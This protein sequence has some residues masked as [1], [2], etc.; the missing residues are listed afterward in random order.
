VVRAPRALVDAI[1]QRTP[2][3]TQFV[4][5]GWLDLATLDPETGVLERR[6]TAGG[7]EAWA[8]GAAGG[9]DVPTAPLL[10]EVPT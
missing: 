10:T 6:T 4:D 8:A 9:E 1:V 3:L 2:V 5:H 7:W